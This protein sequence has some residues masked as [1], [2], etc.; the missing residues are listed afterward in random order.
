MEA[1]LDEILGRERLLAFLSML[2]GGVAVA[3]SAIG[4]YGVLA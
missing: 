2:L 1:Q 4:L 3:L